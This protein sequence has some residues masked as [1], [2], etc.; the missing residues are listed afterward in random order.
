MGKMICNKMR[1]C[2]SLITVLGMT[3]LVLLMLVSISGTEPF[4]YI[5]NYDDTASIIDISNGAVTATLP[6]G[7]DPFVIFNR[8][9]ATTNN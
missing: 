2:H 3:A 1:T 7:F 5:T 4:A 6:A 9:V 8:L